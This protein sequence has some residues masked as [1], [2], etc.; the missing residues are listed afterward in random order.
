VPHEPSAAAVSGIG[1]TVGVFD[2]LHHG[3][4]RF[5]RAARSRCGHLIAGLQLDPAAGK[6]VVV[7]HSFNQ[8]FRRLSLIKAVDR[9]IP[10]QAVDQLIEA[11]C[12]D[13]L[14]VGEDQLHA[15]FARAVHHCHRRGIPV[16]RLARTCG[17]SSTALRQ[18]QSGRFS[19]VD[20]RSL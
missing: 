9:I 17:I 7:F 11:E 15:G 4:L 6:D 8:R 18:G 14:F 20:S 3:H 1:L 2:L 5:L 12:F 16:T 19:A 13:H 10:Y